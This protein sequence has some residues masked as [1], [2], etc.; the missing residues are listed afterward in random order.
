MSKR[1]KAPK[2]TTDAEIVLL[3]AKLVGLHHEQEVIQDAD[4]Y[5]P[6]KGPLQPRFAAINAEQRQIIGQLYKLAPPST[7]GAVAA[8]AAA[9]AVWWPRNADGRLF[10]DGASEWLAVTIIQGLVGTNAGIEP[11]G[12]LAHF[13][14]EGVQI[15]P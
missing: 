8:L 2:S 3:C 1:Q 6:D 11:D 14:S 5:A 15:R 13:A 4:D 12:C 9:A 7:T 10:C